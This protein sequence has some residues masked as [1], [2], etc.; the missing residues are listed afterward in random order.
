[1]IKK[2]KKDFNSL[3]KKKPKIIVSAPGRINI[4]GEHTDYNYGLAMPAAINKYIFGGGIMFF[5]LEFFIMSHF[6][7]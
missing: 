1:M 6:I 7:F 5:P 3:Y 2:I 4:I